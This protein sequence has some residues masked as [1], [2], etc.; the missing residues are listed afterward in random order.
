[1]PAQLILNNYYHQVS[2]LLRNQIHLEEYF[3]EFDTQVNNCE[4]R[5]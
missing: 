3:L 4:L 5:I 1:M 2:S